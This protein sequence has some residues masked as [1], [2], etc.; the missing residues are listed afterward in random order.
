MKGIHH[1]GGAYWCTHWCTPSLEMMKPLA[2]QGVSGWAIL[3]SN[4]FSELGL[5][6]VNAR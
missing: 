2:P 4:R 5:T 1:D 6:C 3:G